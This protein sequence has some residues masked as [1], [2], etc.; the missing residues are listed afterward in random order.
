MGGKGRKGK[1][2]YKT[3]EEEKEAERGEKSPKG[4]K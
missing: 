1:I 4:R 3:R 2:I